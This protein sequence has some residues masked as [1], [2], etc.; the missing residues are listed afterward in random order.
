MKLTMAG[1]M[2]FSAVLAN[3]MRSFLTML[4]IIIGVVAVTLLV[5][6]VQGAT[7]TVTENLDDL[8][9]DRLVVQI[10]GGSRRMTLWEVRALEDLEEIGYVSPSMSG[11]GTVRAEGTGMDVSVN[12]IT[13]QYEAVQGLDLESGRPFDRTDMDYRLGVAIVGC[14][15]A[16]ELFGSRKQLAHQLL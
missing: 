8:G 16:E 6:L 15:V 1:R 7:N 11:S 13:E 2:A 4:G 12:G 14:E 3:K 9:G 5:S 10:S